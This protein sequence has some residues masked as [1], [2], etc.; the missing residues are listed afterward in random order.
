MNYL[1]QLTKQNAI[2]I[3]FDI[4]LTLISLDEIIEICFPGN[5]TKKSNKQNTF[6]LAVK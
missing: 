2:A 5:K 3:Y 4:F 1:E 6:F